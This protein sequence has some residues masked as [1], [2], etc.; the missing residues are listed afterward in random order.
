MAT[1][2]TRVLYATPSTGNYTSNTTPKTTTSFDVQSGD[3]IVVM[4]G[5]E[6]SSTI[7][8]VTPSASG[9]SVTWTAR[10][11]FPAAVSGNTSLTR[12]WTGAVGAT[13][14]GITVSL[15]S[16][17]AAADFWGFSATLMRAHG[18]V[19]QVFQN[20][21][22]SGNGAPSVAVSCSANSL[23][24]CVVNDWNAIDGATR[25]WRTIN[26]A[27]EIETVYSRTASRHTAYGGYRAD[28][29]AAGSI[30][31]GLTVPSTMRWSLS[32]IEILGTT[33][34]PSGT[35]AETINLADTAAGTRASSGTA[36]ETI[37]FA[38][39]GAGTRTSS[40]T[41]ADTA[42]LADAAAGSV[43]H[44][45]SAAET[46]D[47]ADLAAGVRT[48]VGSAG[49]SVDL[50]DAASGIAP[51]AGGTAAETITATDAAAGT[52]APQG[53]SADSIAVTD[54][55][56]GTAPAVGQND[57]TAAE[58]IDLTDAAAGTRASQ[59]NSVDSMVFA[60]SAIGLVSRRGTIAETAL[61]GENANGSVNM[62][63]IAH[64][65]AVLGDAVAGSMPAR[66][67]AAE[68]INLED[69]ADSQT[70]P[71]FAIGPDA[72]EI[73]IGAETVDKVYLGAALIYDSA[74]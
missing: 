38:D 39:L 64:D 72:A 26:G 55:A 22:T 50:V 63:G 33:S 6:N 5:A 45:G 67:S 66:G 23:V 7:A 9:G 59:G 24:A 20:G 27:A 29:G 44:Q 61:I 57:G 34:I 3:L 40:G 13:A 31:Q 1:P 8:S 2:P 12:V 71:V 60:D 53:S 18:G 69:K 43:I 14:T 32:G 47:A 56:S 74:G 52:F 42:N 19:G 25:T 49:D 35:A 17:S 30:T 4:A 58:T 11:Q 65:S 10:A 62:T 28:T 46:I 73:F 21:I 16:I 51:P 36:A 48:P 41:A 70:T 68:I 54:A 37:N 15:A